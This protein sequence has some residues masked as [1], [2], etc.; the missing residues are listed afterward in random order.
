M[1]SSDHLP[2]YASRGARALVLL[3]DQAL[4][5]FVSVWRDAER[6]AIVLPET[7]D[8]D[9]A[10]MHALLAHVLGA[11]S[12]YMRWCC[13]MLELP[14]PDLPPRPSPDTV[15]DETDALLAHTLAGWRAPLAGVADERLHRP[16]FV[17]RWGVR[18]CVDAMLEHAV[19]HPLRHSFQ[20]RQLMTSGPATPPVDG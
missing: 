18:Y 15:A 10:S 9:Y 8:P 7:D 11:A 3:H 5:E 2:P 17:S 13:E 16:E 14:E 4:T 1:T 19:M 20:L 12:G 6:A